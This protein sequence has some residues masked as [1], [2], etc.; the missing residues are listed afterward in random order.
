MHALAAAHCVEWACGPV[1][2]VQTPGV[3]RLTLAD[4]DFDKGTKKAMLARLPVD[5][6]VDVQFREVPAA[7]EGPSAHAHV[8]T[9]GLPAEHHSGAGAGAGVGAGAAPSVVTAPAPPRCAVHAS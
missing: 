2:R 4:L 1:G 3:L 7:G 5:F 6:I 8:D 9:P